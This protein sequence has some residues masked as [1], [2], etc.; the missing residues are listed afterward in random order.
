MN[1]LDGTAGRAYTGGHRREIVPERLSKCTGRQSLGEPGKSFDVAEQER[2]LDEFAAEL[3]FA[4]RLK[5]L[6]H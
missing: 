2:Y 3:R 1:L 4:V 5:E 6:P